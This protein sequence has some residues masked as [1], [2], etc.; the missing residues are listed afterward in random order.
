MEI[1]PAVLAE[2]E[3]DFFY[4]IRQA[5]T[6]TDYVQIDIMD[7]F[8]VPSR[9][10]PVPALNR[11]KT[12]LAFEIHLMV[13]HP[14][15]FMIQVDH[16]HL[17]KVF[18]HIESEVEPLDFISQMKNR[19]IT[20]GLA[21]N[22]ETPIEG[23]HHLTDYVD[24]ILF[25]T[26]DPGYYGSPFKPEVLDKIKETRSRFQNILIGADGGV[27]L[28]NLH[29][30]IDAGIDFACMGSRIFQGDNPGENYREF[31]RRIEDITKGQ[32]D[33]N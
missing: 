8:F 12:T 25:M 16:P 31:L 1:I 7:G 26:V 14:S 3:N 28:D 30:L 32:G 15:A 17:K 33:K 13:K 22:P 20:P 9:S 18:F 24:T 2:R 11:L 29:V 23:F 19:G 4:L 6:F 5:E 10:F 21:I 27:S